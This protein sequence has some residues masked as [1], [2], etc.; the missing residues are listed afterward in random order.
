[1]K[2][3]K[4][5]HVGRQS[6]VLTNVKPVTKPQTIKIDNTNLDIQDEI[7]PWGSDNL[8]PQKFYVKYGK[9]GASV[10]GQNALKGA[11]Y[12]SGF[13]LLKEIDGPNG[14]V[15]QQKQRLSKYPD[16]LAFSKASKFNRF[17]FETI[18]DQS[19][20]QIAFTE[21]VLS[22]DFRKITQVKRLQAA[23]CRF[24]KQDTSGRIR[25]VYLNTDWENADKNF[26]NSYY[27][28]DPDMSVDEIRE[29]CSKKKVYS[30]VTATYYPL[31]DESYYPKADWHAVDRSG[32]MDVANSVP[33]LKQAIFENQLHFK[34]IIYVSDLYFESFYK[35]EWD[36]FDADKRQ[37]MREDLSDTIDDIMSGNKA[38]GRSL[39]APIFEENGKFVKGIEVHPV[40]NKLKDGSYLPDAASANAEILFAMG[41]DPAL[42]G[43]G[44]PGS[45]NLSGSGSDKREAY[46]ILC[47]NLTPRRHLSLEIWERIRDFNLWP[48][49]L[50]ATFPNINLTTLDK[51]PDGQE[52]I[53]H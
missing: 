28:M 50:E 27:Y 52:E 32:W 33:E 29:F 2:H 39:T 19:I 20:F 30:F 16:I 37:Q 40:D 6:I 12:G 47:A 53:I 34:Y 22:K 43:A 42:V 26:T 13:T 48:E 31:I 10:G 1:M 5:I 3:F 46:T 49:D 21:Y 14:E 15:V 51:N 23:H 35:D 7:V 9:N 17:W 41:V 8:Y 45:S 24:G 4:N 18:T 11:H 36:D 44:I 25:F 38:G